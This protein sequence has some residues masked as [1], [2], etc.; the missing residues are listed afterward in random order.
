[1]RK[2]IKHMRKKI[3]PHLSPSSGGTIK[4]RSFYRLIVNTGR[5]KPEELRKNTDNTI[6]S[7]NATSKYTH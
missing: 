4:A 1:M 7:N 6:K 3:S 5:V 2:H